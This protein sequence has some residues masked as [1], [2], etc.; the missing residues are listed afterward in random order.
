MIVSLVSLSAHGEG[1]VA[2]GFSISDGSHTQNERVILPASAVVDLS[3]AV[4]VCDEACMD[5]VLAASEK[6]AAMKKGMVL[7]SFGRQS[8]KALAR[9]LVQK[10]VAREMAA[11]AVKELIRRGYLDPCADAYAEAERA[12]AKGWGRGRISSALY[13]KG[14]SA[15]TV[16]YALSRLEED[17]TDYVA[18]CA[19]MIRRRYSA[20]PDDP[21][22][23]AKMYAS[24]VRY[25]YTSSDIREALRLLNKG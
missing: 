14:F 17:G 8:P 11:E 13:E 15:Q 10:G 23:R 12:K 3:L 2:V 18:A 1:E 19:E 25:G 22:D 21:R 16:R 5:A 6:H 4:G 20:I 9:K 24:L 7:L